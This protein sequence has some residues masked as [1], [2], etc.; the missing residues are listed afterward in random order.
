M[1]AL[2]AVAAIPSAVAAQR[3]G[4]RW[5]AEQASRWYR[6]RV[7]AISFGLVAG[8]MNTIYPWNNEAGAVEPE[9]WFH[10]IFR[11]DGSPFDPEEIVLIKKLSSRDQ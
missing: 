5:S 8:K 9:V 10:D 6:E 11:P 1:L 3:S 2:T 4:E 7:G